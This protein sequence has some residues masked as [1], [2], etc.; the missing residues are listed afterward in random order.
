MKKTRTYSLYSTEAGILL[1]KQI[2][3]GRK[4]RKWTESELAERAGISRATVQKIEK[5]D[6]TCAIGLMFEAAALVGVQL[7]EKND[8]S[9]NIMSGGIHSINKQ[10]EQANDKIALLPK[11]VRKIKKELD[12]AF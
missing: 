6:M 9:K 10:I 8:P 11:A 7:F 3:L 12:D 4:Q 1:G 2:Q 5:G